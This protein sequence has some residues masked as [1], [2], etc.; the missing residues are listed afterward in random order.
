VELR[1]KVQ[2]VALDLERNTVACLFV[3]GD[4]SQ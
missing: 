3:V 4:R 1:V 2:L